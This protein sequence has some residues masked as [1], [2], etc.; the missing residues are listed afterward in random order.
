MAEQETT[1][2][3]P[4]SP[5]IIAAIEANIKPA[6]AP[7]EKP[8]EQAPPPEQQT[9]AEGQ[10]E[11]EPEAGENKQVEGEDAQ[12]ADEPAT[13]EIPLE[14]LEAIALETEVVGVDGQKVV[15]K[16]T[17]K[18]LKLGYMRQKDYQ[19]KTQ[20]LAKQR[21]ESG[22][23]ARQAVETERKNYLEQLE[24]L[25]K[26]LIETAAPELKTAD[27]NSLAKNDAFEYV[28]LRNQAD[29][30][31]S[32]VDRVQKAINEAKA[33]QTAEQKAA[34]ETALKTAR[35]KYTSEIPGYNDAL[36]AQLVKF[37]ESMGF[38]A[39]EINGWADPRAM[40]LLHTAFQAQ[41]RKPESPA[42]AKKVAIPPKALKP[43]ADGAQATNR[44]RHAEAMQRLNKSGRVD[45]AAAVIRARLGL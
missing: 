5:S 43:G 22:E 20:E 13:G 42:P 38:K 40:K 17:V 21:A 6:P 19:Y 41:A 39:D 45:D 2:L 16:P 37:G 28:R 31:V 12:A 7:A 3:S 23:K 34:H 27:W 9:E 18:E 36:Q 26:A 15:E 32:A 4:E 24:V 44:T 29:Q 30:L 10:P 35:E 25:Q 1:I 14:Q 33:K 8:A 11:G